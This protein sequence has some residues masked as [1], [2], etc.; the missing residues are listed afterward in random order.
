MK[1]INIRKIYYHFVHD[2]LTINNAVIVIALIIATSWVWGSLQ[3]M[4]R[5]YSLQKELDDKK[6]QLIIAQLDTENA[7][8]EQR[9][10]KTKEYQELAVREKLGLVSP[11]E[12]VLILP[13]NS[14]A[15]DKINNT[16]NFNNEQ[17]NIEHDIE[18]SSNFSQWMNFL[19]GDK[20]NDL[21]K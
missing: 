7:K 2:Y 4:Q 9:Y 16:D 3:M 17:K 8:L 5:N 13:D 11:G 14:K 21:I 20:H 15:E 18:S 12:R 10:Y 6:R 1:K 19:F